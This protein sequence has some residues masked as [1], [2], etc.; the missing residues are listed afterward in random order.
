MPVPPTVLGRTPYLGPTLEYVADPLGMM[1]RRYDRHGPVSHARFLGKRWT[2]LLGPDACDHALRNP[3]KAFASGPGWGELVGPFFDR[4]LMLLDFG[5]HHAHRRLMQQAF[6]RDRLEQYAEAL[7]PAVARGLAAWPAGPSAGFRSYWALKDLTLGLAT[8]VFLGETEDA[9]PAELAEVNAAFV[10]CVQAATSF[11]RAPLPGTR[12]RRA[13][14]GRRVLERYLRRRL[15]QRRARGVA[16]DDSD[17]LSVLCAV[18]DDEAGGERFDDRSIVDHMIFLLMAAHDTSTLTTSTLLD[19]LGRDPAWQE[20]C[21]EEAAGLPGHPSL[22]Q[23]EGLESF[24]LAMKE[25]LRLVPPVPV[26]ARR[27]V[28]D[29]EV[30]GEPIPAGRLTSVMVH[31]SHHMPEL[32]TDPQ[33]FDPDRFA[34]PRREDKNHRAAWE[35]FGGGVHKCLGMHFAGLEIKLLLHQL[36][37]RYR[38]TTPNPRPTPLSYLSLPLPR[39]G[40]PIDLTPR[41]DR[42][43]RPAR[44]SPQGAPA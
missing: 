1:R 13:L 12:W 32:W 21:R 24:D 8:R 41:D 30:L 43:D 36:L 31:L 27:A 26:I 10:A 37:R 22:G 34:A 39:D 7:G 16:A 19:Q 40:L 23:L 15:A 2:I 6:T 18:E 3:D 42:T 33:R 38:W 20:R 28:E 5:E 9:D 11:V 14:E 29:T 35:P 25:A 44:P 4:G 17:L